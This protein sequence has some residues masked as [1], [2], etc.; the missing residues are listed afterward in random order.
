MT[1]LEDLNENFPPIIYS[2]LAKV[3]FVYP[4]IALGKWTLKEAPKLA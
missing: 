1:K 2:Y 4:A 3:N